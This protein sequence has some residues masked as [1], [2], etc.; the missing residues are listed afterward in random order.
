[1][2]FRISVDAQNLQADGLMD[3]LSAGTIQFRSGSQ[4]AAITD[5]DTGTLI[6]TLTLQNPASSGAS[7]G[8]AAAT[9]PVSTSSTVA[10]TIGWARVKTSGG[11]AI[12]DG[13]VSLPGGGG[14]IEVTIITL[15]NDDVLQLVSFTV[16]APSI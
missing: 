4:P 13:S 16:T 2:T 5:P 3:G 12:L 8:V 14:D 10:G 15:V 7:G 1:M 9:L 11:T 6:G